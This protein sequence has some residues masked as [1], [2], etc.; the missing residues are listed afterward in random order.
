M[1]SEF[2]DI[3]NRWGLSAADL[4]F[5]QESYSAALGFLGDV[6]SGTPDGQALT[7]NGG[8]QAARRAWEGSAA[9]RRAL[10]KARQEGAQ[11]AAYE[12]ARAES[13]RGYDPFGAIP[14]RDDPQ[15]GPEG[16]LQRFF[17]HGIEVLE[18]KREKQVDDRFV[19]LEDMT[20]EQLRTAHIQHSPTPAAAPVGVSPFRRAPTKA[21]TE[22]QMEC[23]TFM[24]TDIERGWDGS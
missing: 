8:S 20:S 3:P 17:R 18:G 10:G 16:W 14:D 1:K 22:A 23:G 21:E 15:P 13:T 11:E 7:A 9:F 4:D 2:G 6:A 19:A 24:P 12:R 5:D